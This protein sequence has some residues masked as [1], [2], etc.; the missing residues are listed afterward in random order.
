MLEKDVWLPIYVGMAFYVPVFAIAIGLPESLHKAACQDVVSESNHDPQ[1]HL[2]RTGIYSRLSHEIQSFK[3]ATLFF[4]S[5]NRFVVLLLSTLLTTTLGKHAQD[6]ILQFAR[7]R[8]GWEWSQVSFYH[9]R[10]SLQAMLIGSSGRVSSYFESLHCLLASLGDSPCKWGR[11]DEM[12]FIHRSSEGPFPSAR[13]L[14]DN[15]GGS[16][17]DWSF[18]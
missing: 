2:Q 14:L 10:Q 1:E 6:I 16:R 9:P 13:Q 4:V 11:L 8:Y 5:R 18:L 7:R 15:A 3:T 12:D 17:D